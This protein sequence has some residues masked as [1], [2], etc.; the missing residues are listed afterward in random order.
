MKGR[1]ADPGDRAPPDLILQ[2][3]GDRDAPGDLML[4]APGDR[5]VAEPPDRAGDTPDEF[6]RP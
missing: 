6:I 5:A 2:A 3:P 1:R 4:Y